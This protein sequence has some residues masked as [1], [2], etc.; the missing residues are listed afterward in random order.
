MYNYDSKNNDFFSV[1]GER[2][3][4]VNRFKPGMYNKYD[5]KRGL[6]NPNGTGVLVG[7]TEIGEVHSY[8][9]DDNEKVPV[10][11]MLRYRGINIFDLVDGF[12]EEKRF[13]FEECAY[14]LLFGE[15]PTKDEL[16]E[17]CQILGDYRT[18][19]HGFMR[20]VILKYPSKDIMN[21]L[22]RSVLVGYSFDPNPD[23][24]SIENVF[25]QSI[26]L[27][28][29]F[30][31][32][33]AYGY[34]AK[35]H[36]YDGNSLYIHT[37]S[38]EMSTAENF[39]SLI[40]GDGQY[41]PSEAAILDLSLVLHAEH[42]GGNNSS[43]VTHVVS[44]SGTDTYSTIAAALGSLKGPKHGGANIKVMRMM[45]NIKENLTDWEDEGQIRDY[46]T[47]ILHKEAFDNSGL[48]YGIGHAVYTLSDPRC[49]LLKKN[50]AELAKEKGKEEEFALYD[51]IERIAPEVFAEIRKIDKA[52]CANVDFYS[53][54]VYD[55]LNIP[56]DL[57]TPL[58]AV[59]RIVGWCAHRIEEIL[60]GGRII[61][62]AYKNIKGRRNYVKIEDRVFNPDAE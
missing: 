3:E 12:I 28:A 33:A 20:D 14:L 4:K 15:L 51:R 56:S 38:P 54:F 34:Q 31:V 47:K 7:L 29:T 41:T 19:P 53:G 35:S 1:S 48:I 46:L 62:P 61:R 57:Y 10:E 36:Y 2:I 9:M 55:M 49:I 32:L 24:I 39:L 23:D 17:F 60:N 21:K 58:F 8:V 52:M 50:A 13:G 16:K 27:I 22:A 30:P 42:G 45:D 43:F 40:R 18:L 26:Q 11:G 44:S 37:P 5:V 59:S 25:R 6:R